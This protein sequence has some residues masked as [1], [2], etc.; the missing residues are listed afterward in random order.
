MS[1]DAERIKRLVEFKKKLEDKIEKLTSEL[2]DSQAMLET[3]DSILLEK[4]FRRLQVSEESTRTGDLRATE[5]VDE[6][7]P[8]PSPLQSPAELENITPLQTTA[9]ELLANLH[10]TKEQLRVILAEDKDFNFNTPPFTHFLLERVLLK[11]QE[12]DNE[13]ARAGQLSPDKILCYNIVR[14]GDVIREI[15]IKNTDPERLKELKSSI[16]WTLEKMYEKMKTQS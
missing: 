5:R 4:G 14:E 10:V 16:R 1:T 11:M 9:G 8:E 3:L 12:R 2:K 13:L 15:D 6:G 7:E